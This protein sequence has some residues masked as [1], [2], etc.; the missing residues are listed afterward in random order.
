MPHPIADAPRRLLINKG[1]SRRTLL[2]LL[3]ACICFLVLWYGFAFGQGIK[4]WEAYTTDRLSPQAA[5]ALSRCVALRQ[6]PGP[7]ARF[8]ER[9]ESDRYVPGT[10]PVLLK[11]A[12]IWSGDKNGTD[13][14][15]SDILLDKGIIKG[16]GR[17]ATRLA[18]RFKDD[19]DVI[20]VKHAWVTPGCVLYT[21]RSFHALSQLPASST[22]TRTSVTHR[23]PRW[24]EPKTTTPYMAPLSLGYVLWMV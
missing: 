24:T 9:H 2:S 10:K 11:N 20:D 14:F 4:F 6:K 19:I 16:I 3:P 18:K 8:Y 22:C 13:V 15:Y 23:A 1:P 7:P 5:A 21:S 12:K 17:T